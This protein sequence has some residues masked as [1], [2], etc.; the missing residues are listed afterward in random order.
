MVREVEGQSVEDEELV[1]FQ[2][3]ALVEVFYFF[4]CEGESASG[5]VVAVEEEDVALVL[6]GVYG[7]EVVD[8]FKVI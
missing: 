5:S 2:G 6:L 4:F 7:L 1:F 8:H 3:A